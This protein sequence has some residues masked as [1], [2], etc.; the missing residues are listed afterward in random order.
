MLPIFVIVMNIRFVLILLPF[1]LLASCGGREVAG[2]LDEVESVIYERPDSALQQ[3]RAMDPA[4]LGTKSQRARYSLLLAMALDKNYIDT[5]DVSVVMPAV[6]YYR[7][8]GTSDEKM[9]SGYYLGRI[10]FNRG[11][12]NAAAVTFS[13]CEKQLPTTK[14]LRMKGQ[15]YMALSDVYNRTKNLD[16][17]EE[18]VNKG[19]QAFT[20]A[21]DEKYQNLTYGRLAI[22]LYNKGDWDKADSLFRIGINKAENHPLFLTDL[23]SNYAKMKV[24]QPEKDPAGAISLLN[25][26][27]DE[28]RRP[29]SIKDHCVYAY[30]SL[31]VGD[32]QTCD[33]LVK[34]LMQLTGPEKDHVIS[35]MTQIEQQKG[36]YAEA[37]DYC[38]QDFSHNMAMA[39]ELISHSA[40]QALNDYLMTETEAVKKESMIKT[41]SILLGA[42]SIILALMLL[43]WVY[44]RRR[45]RQDAKRER[46]LR[47]AEES[48]L[49][50]QQGF[51]EERAALLKQ[52][53]LYSR[54]SDEAKSDD[55]KLKET[56]ESLRK[57]YAET[58]KEK[59]ASVGKLCEAYFNA[60]NRTDK[61]EIIYRKVEDMVSFISDDDKLHRKFENQINRDLNNIV[62]HLKAD[63]GNV[64][65]M[66][67]RFICYCIVGFA[68][69][70]I[71][72]VLNLSLSNVY[73]KK[74]RLKEKIRNLESPYKDEY[75]RMI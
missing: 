10:Q 55:A 9:R 2:T 44:K 56:L 11:D 19:I 35:W 57:V 24:L 27:R 37:L 17:E 61:S 18:Y 47:I 43:F 68:P 62:K 50:L 7:K 75:L 15:L 72:T 6:D 29:L 64:D 73:T 54:K 67:S 8:H 59:Y 26:R 23:L 53:E 66:E 70:M 5:T 74:S 48:N 65:K 1:F 63:L 58:Y 69:E 22:L 38:M 12:Y 31:L 51:D 71:G 45:D 49:I 39:K 52:V 36:N 40:T 28:F 34:N 30:A 3:L 14:D 20:E 46:L 42:L 33:K 60:Q 16:K 41:L 32:E 13:L 4:Q 21:G 25:R